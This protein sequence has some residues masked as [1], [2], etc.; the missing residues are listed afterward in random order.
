MLVLF[1]LIAFTWE[2][3]F[4]KTRHVY[5]VV[6]RS[7]ITYESSTWHA[8]HEKSNTL[9]KLTNDIIKLQKTRLRIICDV[10]KTISHQILDVQTQIQLIKLHLIFL[11]IQMRMRLHENAHNTLTKI[12]CDK[13]KWKLTTTRERRRRFVDTTLDERKRTWFD[14]LCSKQQDTI[15]NA[16]MLKSKTFKKLLFLKWKQSWSE[17]Q[18]TNRRRI[19]VALTSRL[20][21]KWL[22]LHE[23]L[24]KI[25]SNLVIQMRTNHINLIEYLFHRKMLIISSSIC[26]CNWLKQ[27]TKHV[28]FFCSNYRTHRESMLKVVETFNFDTMLNTV[29]ELKTMIKWMMKINLLAQFSLAIECLE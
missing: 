23:N 28:V 22:K 10:F 2:V 14:K 1:R 11:Q 8:S 3:C 27:I 17:Y 26:F 18:I 24:F 16:N 19:C 7:I 13:I 15:F 29:K 25:E 6:V 12:H 4:K 5:I 20:F 21:R 9:N